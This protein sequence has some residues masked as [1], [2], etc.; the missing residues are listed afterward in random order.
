MTKINFNCAVLLKKKPYYVMALDEEDAKR[1]C[2]NLGTEN[3]TGVVVGENLTVKEVASEIS[4]SHTEPKMIEHQEEIDE[5][6]EEILN[7]VLE[8]PEEEIKQIEE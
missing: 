7:E 8:E 2:K 5:E 4:F 1:I 3:V 6:Q